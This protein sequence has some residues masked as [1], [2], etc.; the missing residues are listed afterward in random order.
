MTVM[1]VKTMEEFEALFETSKEKLVVI[2]FTAS[3]CGPCRYIG[4]IFEKMAEETPD[5]TFVK[6]DVDEAQE[7]SA[8]CGVQAM[9]TFQF[10]KDGSKIDE[11]RGADKGKLIAMVEELRHPGVTESRES[12]LKGFFD[13]CLSGDVAKVQKHLKANPGFAAEATP[14]EWHDYHIMRAGWQPV[15]STLNPGVMNAKGT[16]F[17]M[18]THPA[19]GLHLAAGNGHADVVKVLIDANANLEAKDGDDDTALTWATYCGRRDVM[20]QLMIAGADSG[21]ADTVSRQQFEAIKGDGASLAY[22]QNKR[23]A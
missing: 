16:V 17:V 10:F 9:P 8:A 20:D 2:D 19:Y 18:A 4:P 23:K 1:Y 21:F 22:L 11:M 15:Q 5:V 3:W 12:K 6:I 14:K 7:V 13:A